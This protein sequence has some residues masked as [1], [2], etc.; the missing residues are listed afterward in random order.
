MNGIEPQ[1]AMAASHDPVVTIGDRQLSLAEFLSACARSYDT[2]AQSVA[3][4]QLNAARDALLAAGLSAVGANATTCW[5]QFG[6]VVGKDRLAAVYLE[7]LRTAEEMLSQADAENFFF[8]HK[9][10]GLRVRFEAARAGRLDLER[11]LHARADHWQDKELIKRVTPGVYEPEAHLFGGPESMRFVHRLFTA[12]SLAWLGYH[13]LAANT[14]AGT[15]NRQPMSWAF[16]LRLLREF[17]AGLNV[18]GWEDHDV[19]DR[20]RRDTGRCLSDAHLAMDGFAATALAIR[21]AWSGR[22]SRRG[23][24]GPAADNLI[25]QYGLVARVEGHRW[26]DEYFGTRQAYVGPRE[27]AA[28]YIVYHWNRG[29]LPLLRQAVIAESLADP[30]AATR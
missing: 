11:E 25:E 13:V 15:C 21:G 10:P 3:D 5:V 7:L 16:S 6:L 24:L 29:G 12:D 28:Y 8:M 19:W 9:P 27:A 18:A 22:N 26:L 30:E 1:S 23:K 17:F 2:A 4:P 14:E 20:V